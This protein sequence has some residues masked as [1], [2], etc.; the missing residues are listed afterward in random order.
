MSIKDFSAEEIRFQAV[1]SSCGIPLRLANKSFTCYEPICPEKEQ[2]LKKCQSF[3]AK[4]LDIIHQGYGLFLQGP[5][6]TGKS[7]LAVSVLRS[8]LEN[9]ISHFGMPVN[10]FVGEPVYDG[11]YCYMISVIDLLVTLR[12]SFGNDQ[13][14]SAARNKLHR[15]RCDA[16]VILDD[17]GAEKPS[18]FV[19]EQL[20]ALIDLRYRM[21]RSTF[22]TTNCTLKQLES[23]I[24]CRTVSRIIE[25]CEGVK[26]GGDDWRKR[27]IR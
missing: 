22:F 5:V 1:W 15:T 23:Q 27:G 20:Y 11:Y 14:K 16:V 4:G 17:I 2:A 7:H 18:E 13:L 25:M 26:V 3:A 9:N 12:E 19:E 24:G 6:G 8:L 21:Q 10:N